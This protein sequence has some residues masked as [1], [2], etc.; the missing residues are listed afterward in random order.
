MLPPMTTQMRQ[1]CAYIGDP[2][3]FL[4]SLFAE[5]DMGR[6]AQ[7]IRMERCPVAIHAENA[8]GADQHPAFGAE[9]SGGPFQA[10]GEL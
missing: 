10:F 3:Y 7:H 1:P 2:G 5:G 8:F 9:A 6:K 4:Q